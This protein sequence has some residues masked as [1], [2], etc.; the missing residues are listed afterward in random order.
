[1]LKY[2]SIGALSYGQL[3]LLI[4]WIN[5]TCLQYS[6]NSFDMYRPPRLLQKYQVLSINTQ[7]EIQRFLHGTS[8][9]FTGNVFICNIG[10][11]TSVMQLDNGTVISLTAVCKKQTCEISTPYL[12]GF[13][14]NIISIQF[15][16]KH[17][18]GY[19]FFVSQI[20]FYHNREQL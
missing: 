3:A 17:L 10:N 16:L 2:P 20:L 7:L 15:V 11:E 12:I 8:C 6:V 9:Q 13:F 5:P 19:T 18:V 14:C 4:F 1:M